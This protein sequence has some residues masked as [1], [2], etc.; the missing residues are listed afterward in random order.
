MNKRNLII[1]V[2]G[3]V[4]LITGVVLW[5]QK[6]NSQDTKQEVKQ[7]VTKETQEQKQTQEQENTQEQNNQNQIIDGELKPEEEIDTSNWKTYRNEEY[8]FEFK[9]PEECNILQGAKTSSE[10]IAM[11]NCHS[12]KY[13]D[14]GIILP[15]VKFFGMV[16]IFYNDSLSKNEYVKQ[17]QNDCVRNFGMKKELVVKKIKSVSKE[18]KNKIEGGCSAVGEPKI[19]AIFDANNKKMVQFVGNIRHNFLIK[20]I[21]GQNVVDGGHDITNIIYRT[22]IFEK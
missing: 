13:F 15:D 9:Y 12:K 4:I 14:E 10:K 3:L 7:Q 22:F 20:N 11:L 2:T 8:G 19:V 5:S 6:N 21:N 16:N 18:E 1:G 17:Q